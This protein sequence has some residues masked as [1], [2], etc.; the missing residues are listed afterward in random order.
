MQP[1]DGATLA[2]EHPFDLMVTSF[3]D[4]EPCFPRSQ[5]IEFRWEAGLL[6]AVEHKSSTRK[7]LGQIRREVAINRYLVYLAHF[8]ARRGPGMHAFAAVGDEQNAGCVFIQASNRRNGGISFEPALRKQLVN[9]R[10]F[11]RV[12]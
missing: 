5:D 1:G 9:R 8:G 11:G 6:F 4:L 2:R 12:V 3:D 10:S 7:K